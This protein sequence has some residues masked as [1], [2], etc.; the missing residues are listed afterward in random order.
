MKK[1]LISISLVLNV[2][3]FANQTQTYIEEGCDTVM[4]KMTVKYLS[5]NQTKLDK[6]VSKKYNNFYTIDAASVEFC[7]VKDLDR[8]SYDVT[9]FVKVCVDVLDFKKNSK[10]AS[11]YLKTKGD[12]F[13]ENEE[14]LSFEDIWLD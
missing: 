10:P 5:K 7:G 2:S 1:I 13:C 12:F 9:R 8:G 11:V 4:E 3:I 6:L 14:V